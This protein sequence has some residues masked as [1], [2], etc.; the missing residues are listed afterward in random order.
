MHVHACTHMPGHRSHM[1]SSEDNLW[2]LW[3]CSSPSTTWLPRD[4][5]QVSGLSSKR[6]RPL[7]SHDSSV[8][9]LFLNGQCSTKQFSREKLFL[10]ACGAIKTRCHMT[11]EIVMLAPTSYHTQMLIQTWIKNLS[12]K[13]R[14]IEL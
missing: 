2:E 1:W 8:N 11:K 14:T 12:V 13:A 3:R 4:Q 6:C 7:G 10:P 5:T 9:N